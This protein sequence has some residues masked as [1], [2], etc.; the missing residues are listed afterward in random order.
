MTQLYVGGLQYSTTELR[1]LELFTEKGYN[2]VSAR[3][4]PDRETRRSQ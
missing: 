1:L 3:I 2:P 4:I